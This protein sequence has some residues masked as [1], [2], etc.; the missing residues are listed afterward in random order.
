MAPGEKGTSGL[1][2]EIG[3]RKRFAMA[4]GGNFLFR[5]RNGLRAQ[6]VDSARSRRDCFSPSGTQ[7]TVEGWRIGAA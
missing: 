3:I 6:V 7:P 4:S 5:C 1:M 2:A